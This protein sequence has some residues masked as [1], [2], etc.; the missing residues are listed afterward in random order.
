MNKKNICLI[1]II[2]LLLLLII[3][4]FF[5]N[6]INNKTT[7]DSN[8][9]TTTT[10]RKTS[11]EISSSTTNTTIVIDSNTRTNTTVTTKTTT[12]T[13]IKTTTT[14]KRQTTKETTT[15]AKKPS[16]PNEFTLENNKCTKTIDAVKTCPPN[17]ADVGGEDIPQDE[18][19]INLSE[20]YETTD[21]TCPDNYTIMKIIT[22]GSPDKYRCIPLH[23]KE[24]KCEDGYTLHDTNKCTISINPQ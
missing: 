6:K 22:L 19:C 20:G 15:T 10:L 5:I 14:T 3:S 2:L 16:C 12:T 9:K 21:L 23:K 18:Y 8:N 1:I 17:M 13:T 24:Y 11:K 7:I 4:I